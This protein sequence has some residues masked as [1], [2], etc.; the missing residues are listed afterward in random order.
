MMANDIL[1]IEAKNPHI[2]AKSRYSRSSHFFAYP[3]FVF[4]LK[5]KKNAN[6]T[7]LNQSKI[8]K[9]GVKIIEFYR[10]SRVIY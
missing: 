1:F 2:L 9:D 3:H 7:T 8:K 6:R 5:L 10:E 4:K